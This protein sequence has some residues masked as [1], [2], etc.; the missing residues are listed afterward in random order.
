MEVLGKEN[1]AKFI[2]HI[3]HQRSMNEIARLMSGVDALKTKGRVAGIRFRH[4]DEI[5]RNV[6]ALM[7]THGPPNPSTLGSGNPLFESKEKAEKEVSSKRKSLPKAQEDKI[8]E[9]AL[10]EWAPQRTTFKKFAF[11]AMRVNQARIAAGIT[12]YVAAEDYEHLDRRK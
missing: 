11:V 12:S 8:V 10:N 3:Y 2:E 4:M 5:R 9:E 7:V 6:A 1:A